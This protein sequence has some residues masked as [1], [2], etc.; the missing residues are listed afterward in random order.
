MLGNLIRASLDVNLRP[1]TLS[2]KV[3]PEGYSRKGICKFELTYFF[4]V[5]WVVGWLAP[6]R[7]E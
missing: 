4:G 5:V 1:K 7:T 3:P 2:K 6:E